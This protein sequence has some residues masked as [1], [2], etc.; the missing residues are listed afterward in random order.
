[1]NAW[2]KRFGSM[3]VA[4]AVACTFGA[5]SALADEKDRPPAPK[6]GVPAVGAEGASKIAENLLGVQ[7]T[8]YLKVWRSSINQLSGTKVRLSGSTDTYD[9]VNLIEVHLYLQYWNEGASRWDDISGPHIFSKTSSSK[10][11][12]SVD[13]TLSSGYYYRTKAVHR[14]TSN[15][16]TEQQVSFTDYIY[17]E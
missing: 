14:A 10:V 3:L 5:G 7:S 9:D 16:E 17:I 12:G 15:A 6:E 13:I 2:S 11:S 1:M 8:E 4:L